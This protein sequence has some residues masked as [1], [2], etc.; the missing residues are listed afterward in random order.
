MTCSW[1]WFIHPETA[2]R[3]NRNGSSTLCVFQTH[4]RDRRASV[5]KHRIFMQIQFSGHTRSRRRYTNVTFIGPPGPMG[6]ADLPHLVQFRS[7]PQHPAADGG[8]VQVQASFRHELFQIP[9]CQAL[10]Q[11]PPHAKQYV[12]R[13]SDVL[14]TAL[15]GCCAMGSTLSNPAGGRLRQ[16]P[17]RHEGQTRS[18]TIRAGGISLK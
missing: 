3:K 13:E 15:A 16:I 7:I 10:L 6:W 17:K 9:Q 2:I 8:M 14:G 4:H 5:A 1:R 11:V 12:D 18:L